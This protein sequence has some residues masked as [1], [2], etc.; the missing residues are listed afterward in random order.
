MGYALRN[1]T[2]GVYSGLQRRWRVKAKME[3]RAV[4]AFDLD[5]DGEVEVV[6]GWEGGRLE[7]RRADTGQLVYRDD[8]GSSTGGLASASGSGGAG[9]SA[10]GAN[11]S[12][13]SSLLRCD[14]RRSQEDALLV[15]RADGT[16]QGFRPVEAEIATAGGAAA[17]AAGLVT[18]SAD[19]QAVQELQEQKGA[20]ETELRALSRRER[21]LK[22]GRRDGNDLHVATALQAETLQDDDAAAILVSLRVSHAA[23]IRSALAVALDSAALPGG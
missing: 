9:S 2:V 19:A 12:S 13:I 23:H 14:Y 20:L 18:T 4:G 5:A 8:P 16:V 15:V 6:S 17:A 10:S 3:P 1:G 7:A 11:S 22:E 21:D